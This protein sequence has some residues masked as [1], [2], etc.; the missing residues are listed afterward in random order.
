MITADTIRRCS[1]LDSIDLENLLR[2]SFPQDVVE[3][4]QFLGISN[5]DQFVYRITYPDPHLDGRGSSMTKVFVW[6]KGNGELVAE[7]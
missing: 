3:K 7:Y 2:K 1:Q 6:E 5:G 4:S